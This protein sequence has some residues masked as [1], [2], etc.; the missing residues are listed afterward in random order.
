FRQV[1]PRAQL[2][3]GRPRPPGGAEDL[4]RRLDRRARARHRLRP[5]GIPIRGRGDGASE[6]TR[7]KLPRALQE[8]AAAPRAPAAFAW[9]GR[10]A[11]PWA[12]DG[13]GESGRVEGDVQDDERSPG[14]RGNEGAEP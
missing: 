6:R 3:G 2:R 10:A 5:G 7:G 9:P 12:E 8:K 14:V 4:L 13:R 1:L 11:A